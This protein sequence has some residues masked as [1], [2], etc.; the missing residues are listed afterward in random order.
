MIV[1]D[2]WPWP[3]KDS[4]NQPNYLERAS[5]E[6]MSKALYDSIPGENND[7]MRIVGYR[8]GAND[9]GDP[10]HVRFINSFI[11]LIALI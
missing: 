11:Q 4:L 9:N 1:P 6:I 8:V 7:Q 2:G 3:E 10:T 5:V